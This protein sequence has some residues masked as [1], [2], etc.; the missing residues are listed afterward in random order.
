M[1]HNV[2]NDKS[3]TERSPENIETQPIETKVIPEQRLDEFCSLPTKPIAIIASFLAEQGQQLDAA[4]ICEQLCEDF[5]QAR[6]NGIHVYEEKMSFPCRYLRSDGTPVEIVLKRSAYEGKPWFLYYIDA[7]PHNASTKQILPGK[8]LENFAFLGSWSSFLTELADK[9]LPETWDFGDTSS[10]NLHILMQYIKYTFYRLTKE[11][12]ICVSADRQFAAFNTG[13]IDK[14]YDDIYACFVPN[15]PNS[16]SE[17]KF[18]GFSTAASRNLG[19]SLVKYFNPLPQPAQYFKRNEDL[20][21]DLEKPLHPDFEH[22]IIDNI[23]RLPLQF[24]LDQLNDCPEAQTII[25]MLFTADDYVERRLYDQL[26]D[27]I[28]NN[29]KLFVRLQNRIKD[30]IEL[31]RKRVRRN[32]KTAIPSYFPT[33]DTMSLMLPLCLTDEE[34]PDVALVVELTPSG[35]YQGQ[36]IL[37]MAQA[38]IDARLLCSMSN[39]WLTIAAQNNCESYDEPEQI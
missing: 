33:Q 15:D 10:K 1:I 17:W 9:A 6:N 29:H 28:S 7:L 13:L 36:T 18:A 5:D 35:N 25:K 19:K 11:D 27:V 8:M 34:H 12:K 31:A 20:I 2:E 16:E 32:Y 26:R 38:Y 37:T 3:K 22:I 24:L 30:S 4:E 23:S 39:D 14:Q 21:F